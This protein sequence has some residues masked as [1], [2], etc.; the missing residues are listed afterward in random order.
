MT[1]VFEAG[2]LP[3]AQKEDLCMALLDEFGA[4]HV[5]RRDD[6][7]IHGCLLPKGGH[8]DQVRNPTASLNWKK[9]TYKCLGCGS[10]GGLLWFIAECRG[11]SAAEARQ[12]LE[13]ATGT[14]NTLMSLHDLLAFF[15]AL[16]V[17]REKYEPIPTYGEKVLRPWEWLHPY[18]TEVREVP[19][20]TLVKMRVGWD[21]DADRIVIPHFWEDR[22]VGWQSRRLA[23]DGTPK[24]LSSPAFP[25]EQT[26]Y[27]YDYMAAEAVVVESPLSALRHLHHAHIEATFGASITERQIKLL[28]RHPKVVLWTD[29]DKAGWDALED[30]VNRRGKVERLGLINALSG[31]T[32][33][34]VVQS[35]WIEDPAELPDAEFDRLVSEAV[36][37]SIWERPDEASLKSWKGVN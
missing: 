26:I 2:M 36:P 19:E 21:P 13:G 33:T 10:G 32:R 18:M 27:N 22:L 37:W 3:A 23:A 24:Y 29:N 25:R 14:G 4:Q 28:Q 15:D 35:P 31:H 16:Y 30:H 5:T 9:L 1:G 17:K 34:Y 20:E 12:W 6:E 11:T 8:K 7:L